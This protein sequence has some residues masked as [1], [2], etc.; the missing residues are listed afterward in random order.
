MAPPPIQLVARRQIVAPPYARARPMTTRSRPLP[1]ASSRR[2]ARSRRP[3]STGSPRTR[4][5]WPHRG[6]P[7]GRASDPR[8]GTPCPRPSDSMPI[9]AGSGASNDGSSKSPKS[10]TGLRVDDLAGRRIDGLAGR[11]ELED[12]SVPNE[13]PAEPVERSVEHVLR[14]LEH[15]EPERRSGPS[16]GRTGGPWPGPRRS[17]PSQTAVATI[18]IASVLYGGKPSSS[19]V[20]KNMNAGTPSAAATVPA[21]ARDPADAPP[22]HEVAE[23]HDQAGQQDARASG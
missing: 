7:C 6:G 15:R 19:K 17:E 4:T 16:R 23:R 9:V 5:A 3:P 13:E 12:C 20:T 8:P 2:P 21:V 18:R 11:V 10:P 14:E 1:A 22:R